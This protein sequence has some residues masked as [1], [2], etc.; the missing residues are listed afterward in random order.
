MS[1]YIAQV[2]DSE[3]ILRAPVDVIFASKRVKKIKVGLG[4]VK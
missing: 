2:L 1:M 3:L 4:S